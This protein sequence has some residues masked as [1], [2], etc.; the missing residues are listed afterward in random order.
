M[1][2]FFFTGRV[3]LPDAHNEV[4]W[5]KSGHNGTLDGEPRVRQEKISRYFCDTIMETC[6]HYRICR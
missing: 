4:V 3:D 6:I 2:E 1:I 5:R